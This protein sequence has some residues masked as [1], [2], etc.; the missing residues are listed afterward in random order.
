MSSDYDVI[1]LGA[2]MVGLSAACA[3]AELKRK[4]LVIDRRPVAATTVALEQ[5]ARVCAINPASAHFLK[6]LGVYD[7]LAEAVK[8]PFDAMM[9]WD[10]PSGEALQF[11]AA[12]ANQ[13]QLGDIVVNQ[14]LVSVLY[15]RA[16]Q[17]GVQFEVA[18]VVALQR[19]ADEVT[20]QDSAGNYYH[21]KLLVGADGRQSWLRQQMQVRVR[22][23]DYQQQAIVAVIATEKPHQYCAWQVFWPT[24]PLGLLP[25]DNPYRMAMVWSNDNAR[26]DALLAD[27]AAFNCELTNAFESRL[28]F[29]KAVT[30][31]QAIP[32]VNCY[33][34]Q[35][36]LPR[37]ALVGDAAHAIHPL[38]GQGVNLGLMDVQCLQQ[39]LIAGVEKGRDFASERD[40][41][42]YERAR[43]GDNLLTAA[44]MS[45]L[46]A[47]FSR[48]DVATTQ[49][50][51]LGLKVLNHLPWLKQRLVNLASD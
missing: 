33:A 35:Y 21:S 37:M 5:D 45:G 46:K 17:L 48:S 27:P 7:Q 13:Y 19:S 15:Q 34:E 26:A 50:R 23:Q 3:L 41:R 36:T 2:G 10:G 12:E 31:L 18:T 25:L 20:L 43:K 42:A 11:D 8:T 4:V 14:A 39:Q 38:A 22:T 29:L 30:E 6:T 47:L 16:Q 51:A 49:V 9:V 24:G 44:T 40:L 1:V 28:G 32:L